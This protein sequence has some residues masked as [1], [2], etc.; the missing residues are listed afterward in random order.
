MAS[1]NKTTLIGHL[2]GDPEIRFLPDGARTATLTLATTDTWK[3]KVSGAKKEKTEWH[4][5]VFFKGLADVVGEYLKKGAQIY[6]E[7]KLRTRKWT[8]KNG[9]ERY[10]TEIVGQEMQMLGKKAG[11][12]AAT[13]PPPDAPPAAQVPAGTDD[14]DSRF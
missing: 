13:A 14:G 2:G 8:D 5:V 1:L 11:G 6:V 4:R 7:G 3:D 10:T 9:V 12:D